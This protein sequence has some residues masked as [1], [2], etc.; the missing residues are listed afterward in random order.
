ME[1]GASQQGS[2]WGDEIQEAL[3]TKT[4]T[5]KA[6]GVRRRRLAIH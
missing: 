3:R 6:P 2:A 5:P 1:T 4:Y